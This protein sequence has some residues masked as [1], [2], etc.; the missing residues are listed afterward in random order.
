M[1]THYLSAKHKSAMF[2]NE[3]K[4]KLS[5]QFICHNCCKEYKDYSGFWRYK[6]KLFKK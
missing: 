4:Q 2:S 6:Q 5:N 1:D 3:I